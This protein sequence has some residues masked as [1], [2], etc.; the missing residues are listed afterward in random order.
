VEIDR[1]EDADVPLAVTTTD[2]LAGDGIVLSSGEVVDS[3]A[4]SCAIPGLFPPVKIG[5]RWL[6]DGSLS[7]NQPVLQALDL[8]LTTSTSSPPPRKPD[9]GLLGERLPWP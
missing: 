9:N 5:D 6:V 2:A 4:A 1:I 3:P 8:A 7:A